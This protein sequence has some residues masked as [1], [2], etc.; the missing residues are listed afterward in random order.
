MQQFGVLSLGSRLKRLSDH[1][2]SEV[3]TIYQARSLAI[4]STYF[5]ILRLLQN[6]RELSVMEMAEQLGLSH[7]AVSKQVTKMLKEGLLEKRLDRQDQRRSIIGLTTFCQQEMA[8]VEPVLAAIGKELEHYLNRLTGDFLTQLGELERQLLSQH[9]AARVLLRLEPDALVIESIA[10][11]EDIDRF[12]AL[13][14][15]WLE[16]YFSHAIYEQDRQMLNDPLQYVAAGGQIK[17]AR[18]RGQVIGCYLLKYCDHRDVELCKL[19]VDE[20]FARLGVGERLVRDALAEA[21]NLG[22]QSLSLETHTSLESAM[23][24][25]RKLGFEEVDCAAFSVP[26]ADLKM[27]RAIKQEE[28]L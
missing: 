10:G 14:L 15:Q 21:T 25:Y 13:N 2:Y 20:G 23:G 27:S 24:L 26:R 11:Q 8:K 12:R 28:S 18:F 1:L 17:V 5:P 4:S 19:A 22:A 9:Y 3:Q 6:E 16:R 7:P